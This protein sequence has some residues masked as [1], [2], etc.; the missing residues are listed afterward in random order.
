MPYPPDYGGVFDLFYKIKALHQLGIKIHLHCFEYGR[1]EQPELNK[2]CEEVNYYQ[3]EKMVQG[4]PLRLPYIV[5][6]RI[7]PQ[8]LKNILKDNYPV[9]LE[10]IHCTYYLYHGELNNRKVLVR[11]HNVEYEYYRQLA[12][13][14]NNLYKKI[15]FKLES[16]LLKKYE[17]IIASKAKLIAV[18]EKDKITYQKVFS[19]KEVEFLPVFLPFNEVKSETGK[20]NF[21]LYHGNLSVAENEKAAIWLLENIFNQLDIPFIIAGKNPS[22]SLKNYSP[23]NK[24][25]QIIANPSQ[26]EMDELIKN[27]QIHLLP[28]FNTTGIKIKLLNALFNGRFIITNKASLEGTD[29]ET[30]CSIAESPADYIKLIKKLFE[31]P[32]TENDISKRKV[33][34]NK[35]YDNEKNGK[36][37]MEM[38]NR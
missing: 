31:I 5:S 25:V 34:L 15:Y 36:R 16:R 38:M 30:L 7:N 24:N 21:C 33:I 23:K 26:K 10:G 3:R 20:G 8:L 29:L 17:N 37:L 32:F 13:S 6:S 2:Y 12:K 1:G 27:A 14:A 35:L 9:L 18:N 28:S 19:G 4:I 22:F 11:L